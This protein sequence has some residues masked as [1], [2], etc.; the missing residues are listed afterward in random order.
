[1]DHTRPIRQLILFTVLINAAAMLSPIINSGDALTYASI[2]RHMALSHDWIRL[3]VDGQDWLDK[4]H[5]PFWITALSFRLGGVS[6]FTYILPGFLFHLL[7]AYYTYRLA[8]L[9]YDTPTAWLAVLIYVSTFSL[10]D[11]SIEIKAEAFLRGQILGACYHWLRYDADTR[12]RDLWL[13]ALYTGLAVMTKGI[14][15]LLTIA[16]GLVCLWMYRRQWSRPLQPRWWLALA[17][18]LLCAA[19]ELMALHL[20]FQQPLVLGD[21]AQPTSAFKFF[22]WDSQFGRFFNTG[23]I[24][25]HG[26]YPLFFVLVFLWAFM[27]WTGV[28]VATLRHQLVRWRHLDRHARE[29]F[30]YLFSTFACTFVV[31]SATKFQMSYYID[32]LLPFMAILCARF[33][34]QVEIGQAFYRAQLGL[35]GFLVFLVVA[36]TAYVMNT[37]ITLVVVGVGLTAYLYRRGLGDT[38]VKLRFV[39]YSVF[40]VTLV[41]I[42]SALLS[43]SAFS[44]F[45]L[46][47]Q[48]AR[49]LGR[50]AEVPIVVYQMPEVAHELTLYSR[51]PV[52]SVES[53]EALQSMTGRY[54]LVVQHAQADDAVNGVTVVRRESHELAVHKTG[55]L[56]QLLKLAKGTWPLESIDYLEIVR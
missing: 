8:R 56:G 46:A 52:R 17:L 14:F 22:F 54:Y 31:F 29:A 1:V 5:F 47:V 3:V 53:A 4:P 20:Q 2:A 13:G 9:W 26:G 7:G 12:G 30:V 24:Q 23:P 37:A 33:F 18:S 41:F 16:S 25:N 32:I 35:V 42:F 6:A 27:P 43:Y 45:G 15:C 36:L 28:A 39:G 55:T 19:P 38:P 49:T 34:S 51:A 48:A 21:L 40:A 44:R 50:Q 10:L 11:S